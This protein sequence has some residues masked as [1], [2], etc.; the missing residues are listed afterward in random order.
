MLIVLELFVL[1]VWNS[2]RHIEFVMYTIVL[3]IILL[4]V[5]LKDSAAKVVEGQAWCSW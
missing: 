5:I 1:V 3:K 2:F 4:F